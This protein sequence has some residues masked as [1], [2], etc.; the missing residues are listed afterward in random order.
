MPV[1]TAPNWA[2]GPWGARPSQWL[3]ARR[4]PR[5]RPPGRTMRLLMMP[6]PPIVLTSPG[7]DQAQVA[8]QPR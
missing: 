5:P 1:S 3:G 8:H 7:P 4:S 2:L 6:I